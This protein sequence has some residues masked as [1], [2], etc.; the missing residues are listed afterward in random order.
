MNWKCSDNIS[1]GFQSQRETCLAKCLRGW[2]KSL[3]NDLRCWD[4]PKLPPVS[5]ISAAA[6]ILGEGVAG[7]KGECLSPL[8]RRENCFEIMVI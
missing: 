5:P 4:D 8:G 2:A 6:E 3:K 1:P 7:R